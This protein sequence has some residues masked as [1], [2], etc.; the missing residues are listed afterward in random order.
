MGITIKEHAGGA[1]V[2]AAIVA[3][4]LV[5]GAFS[6]TVYGAASIVIWA[7][8][9]A[10]LGSRALPVSTIATPAAAAGLCLAVATML[11]FASVA[12]AGDHGRAFEEAV[13]ASAYLG[14][15]VLAVCTASRAARAQW[16]GGRLGG[17]AVGF[18]VIVLLSLFSHLQPGLLENADLDQQIPTAAGRLAYPLGY[19]NGL[20]ALLAVAAVVL[21]HTA[22]SFPE[23]WQRSAATAVVPLALLGIWLTSSR[24]GAAA[25]VI[26][27]AVLA[28]TAV[29][30]GARGGGAG[31]RGRLAQRRVEAPTAAFAPLPDRPGGRGG[32]RPDR[33]RCRGETRRAL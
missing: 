10:G 3:A 12:W 6:P 33:G 8:V 27:L 24:G 15:F 17:L 19:W 26:G 5:E 9:I 32:H 18:G 11:T 28:A 20:A 14:L 4:A 29:R 1:L 25:A 21:A 7:A 30:C 16:L 23:R 2:A 13:R 22:T 31:R